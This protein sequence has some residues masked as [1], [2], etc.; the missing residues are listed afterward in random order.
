MDNEITMLQ[1]MSNPVNLQTRLYQHLESKLLDGNAVLVDPNSVAMTL[2]EGFADVTADYAF[3]TEKENEKRLAN[4]AQTDADLNL[5][6]SDY[7]YVGSFATP[8][9]ATI[10]ISLD[11]SYIL[12]YGVLVNNRTRMIVIP[13]DTIIK[14]G[15]LR[16]SL[17]YPIQIQ[18][19]ERTGIPLVTYDISEQHP[20]MALESNRVVFNELQYLGFNL[21]VMHLTVYQFVRSVKEITLNAIHGCNEV[22]GYTD[23]FYAVR[24]F[25][26]YNGKRI[27]LRQSLVQDNYDPT[28]PT[29]RLQVETDIKKFLINIP[30]IYFTLGYMGLTLYMELYTTAGNINN[31]V[32]TLPVEQ[33]A[34]DFNLSGKPSNPYTDPLITLPTVLINI[35]SPTTT[36]GT[37][38][39]SFEEKRQRII[40]GSYRTKAQITPLDVEN[41]YKDYGI[42][43]QRFEDNLTNLM[44]FVYKPFTDGAGNIV[45]SSNTYLRISPSAP[46]TTSTVKQN[47]DGTFT[48]LPTA[49]YKFQESQNSCLPLSDD[50]TNYLAKMEK[51]EL[52]EE[53][54]K[55]QYVRTPFHIRLNPHSVYPTAVSYNLMQPVLE[56]MTIMEDNPHAQAQMLS[57]SESIAH[58]QNGAGGFSIKF[59][60][61]KDLLSNI[62]EEDITI[63]ASAIAV[64]GAIIGAQVVKYGTVDDY[65]IYELKL[66]TDY[67]L[68]STN[69]INITNLKD[70]STDLNHRISLSSKFE[71]TY[72][73]KTEHFPDV[74]T[75]LHMFNSVPASRQT[76]NCVLLK[77][78]VIV[79]LGHALD[80]VIY[81]HVNLTKE[82]RTYVRHEVDVYNTYSKDIF[83]MDANG[84][85][86]FDIVDGKVVFRVLHKQG[87]TIIGPDGQPEIK[88]PKG[89]LYLD[90]TGQPIIKEDRVSEY[91][92]NAPIF[93]GK[94]FISEHP[95]QVNFAKSLISMFEANFQIIRDAKGYVTERTNVYFKPSRTMGQI[96]YLA[97]DGLEITLPLDLTMGFKAHVD[98]VVTTTPDIKKSILASAVSVINE[99]LKDD[100]IS[101]TEMSKAIKSRVAYI[102]SIDILGIEGDVSLQTLIN[103][104]TSAQPSLRKMLTLSDDKKLILTENL[105]FDF[106]S[107]T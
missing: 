44:Y 105:T 53:F 88:H 95:L 30:Q 72:M 80:N 84:V 20:L 19:D 40:N 79:N 92:I 57:I 27:E 94:L 93:D 55:V 51:T 89:S 6:M 56:Q 50:E 58:E 36:D 75:P 62:P 15:S 29:A 23:K 25:T 45:Q 77:Q 11:K 26:D 91:L 63:W 66:E 1:L 46:K 61:K 33:V 3:A 24:L 60:V 35:T 49:W 7:D 99:K 68:T 34:I 100:I 10:S 42:R 43:V 103:T 17:Y 9:K 71:I 81:N 64:D 39:Y 2:I 82:K 12:N 70:S 59:I 47:V 18:V 28:V 96:K 106:T 67:W 74:D 37:D 102:E 76:G 98:R 87:D 73:V 83:E 13:K 104:D 48:I 38:G 8:S 65:D 97:D 22:I 21:I 85:P 90:S 101:Q 5:H 4:R 78:S 69:E 14:L 41:Y 54:N 31:N 32:G 107:L 86:L 16:F 52:A